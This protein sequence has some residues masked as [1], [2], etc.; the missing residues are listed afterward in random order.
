MK[1]IFI[2]LHSHDLMQYKQLIF[3]VL[4][5]LCACQRNREIGCIIFLNFVPNIKAQSGKKKFYMP[6][7]L[8]KFSM[9][10]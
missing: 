7:H 8:T 4:M 3:L 10:Y 9:K 2:T 6:N 1:L 5:I